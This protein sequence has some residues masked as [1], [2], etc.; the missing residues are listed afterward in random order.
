MVD[1]FLT[2]YF[3]RLLVT[4]DEDTNKP[5][6]VPV[7]ITTSPDCVPRD[8]IGPP[9][10]DV[11]R[12]VFT[13]VMLP[14]FHT[15]KQFSVIGERYW[16]AVVRDVG[17]LKKGFIFVKK[18]TG[19]LEYPD[20]PEGKINLLG[21]TFGDKYTTTIIDTIKTFSR[22]EKIILFAEK[23]C[24][25]APAFSSCGTLEFCK[26][27]LL[28]CLVEEKAQYLA[29]Y[30]SLYRSLGHDVMDTWVVQSWRIIL[31]FYSSRKSG[32]TS[33]VNI[34]NTYRRSYRRTFTNHGFEYLVISQQSN[35]EF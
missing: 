27:Q 24:T 32:I 17:T 9:S 34:H 1:L 33:K 35:L 3:L 22:D 23:F 11:T 6:Y 16:P 19:Y 10:R 28:S 20:D 25:A 31:A 30:T 18:R 12:T 2:S 15:I 7:T 5:C 29:Y 14:E 4:V 26:E 8:V 21:R 13:P